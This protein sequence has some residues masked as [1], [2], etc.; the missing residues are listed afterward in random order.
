MSVKKNV[1]ASKSERKNF[2]KLSRTWGDKYIIYHNLPYQ[3]VFNTEELVDISDWKNLK[4]FT[5][6]DVDFNRLKK[7]SIDYTL[8]DDN[9]S[10][11]VC[12][13]FDGLQQGFNVGTT[14]YPDKL[15]KPLNPWRRKITE[16]KLKVAH[17]S[18]FPFFVVGSKQFE[19]LPA[20]VGLTI[21]DGLIG[22]IL[23]YRAMQE[24]CASFDL[25]ELGLSEEEFDE[26]QP[27]DRQELLED[28]VLD[29]EVSS[30]FENNP[31]HKARWNLQEELN[32]KGWKEDRLYYPNFDHL[33]DYHE[34]ADA[35]DNA[36]MEGH[37]CTLHTDDFGDVVGE[38]WLPNFRV[39]GYS[40]IGLVG[41]IAALFALVRL[42]QMRANK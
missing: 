3:T 40:G 11:I 29:A 36:I 35:M 19:D 32:I 30:D 9:D 1:F 26:L 15:K 25:R 22:T 14:Y 18:L 5:I 13:E 10:P 4:T 38:A 27:L 24:K 7:T 39:P 41:E 28:W 2:Y 23:A 6:S 31:I 20:D 34:R 12:I 33:T 8:C 17:G 21:V 37:R 16:L 42:R